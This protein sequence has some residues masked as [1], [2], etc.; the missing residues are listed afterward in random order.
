MMRI[1]VK[2]FA[3]LSKYQPAPPELELPEGATIADVLAALGLSKGDGSK[4]VRL[5]F[6]NNAHVG[7]E[8]PLQ[9]GDKVG[10]FPAVGGG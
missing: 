10:L 5:I 8:R 6:C 1:H 7:L 9:D 4:Q 3:T 2:C